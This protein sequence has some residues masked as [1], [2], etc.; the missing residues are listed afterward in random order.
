MFEKY[1]DSI[2]D[3]NRSVKMLGIWGKDGLVLERK[4]YSEDNLDK[5][6]VGAEV[7]EVLSGIAR[8]SYSNDETN[9]KL[10][11]DDSFIWVQTITKDYFFIAIISDCI[12]MSIV[13]KKFIRKRITAR[14]GN[15]KATKYY[16]LYWCEF[17]KEKGIYAI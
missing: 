2:Y 16:V 6:M 17:F 10:E 5:D 1:F 7:A 3:K 14:M 11:T 15:D 13:E 12:I 9:I 4:V 8:L